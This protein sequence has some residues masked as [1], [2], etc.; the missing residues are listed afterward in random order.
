[1]SARALSYKLNYVFH[2]HCIGLNCYHTGLVAWSL[3]N[4]VRQVQGK[5]ATAVCSHVRLLACCVDAAVRYMYSSAVSVWGDRRTKADCHN[6]IGHVALQEFV[7]K[8]IV[9]RSRFSPLSTSA[10]TPSPLT[11]SK[12]KDYPV[13]QCLGLFP[14]SELWCEEGKVSHWGLMLMCPELCRNESGY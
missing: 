5:H 2:I 3:V 1:M 7:Q 13:I 14:N 9:T 6:W 10:N 8:Q 12:K 11:W 4:I